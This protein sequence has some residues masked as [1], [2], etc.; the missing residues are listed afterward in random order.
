MSKRKGMDKAD[1]ERSGEGIS[2][3]AVAAGLTARVFAA[4]WIA[5][6]QTNVQNALNAADR[7]LTAP[8]HA[9]GDHSDSGS[10]HDELPEF[11]RPSAPSTPA[12]ATVPAGFMRV[13]HLPGREEVTLWGVKTI[14]SDALSRAAKVDGWLRD[15][16]G[17]VSPFRWTGVTFGEKMGDLVGNLRKRAGKWLQRGRFPLVIPVA[18]LHRPMSL[19]AADTDFVQEVQRYLSEDQEVN[20]W[21]NTVK[22]SVRHNL[23]I[24]GESTTMVRSYR[25]EPP[26]GL[27]LWDLE[28]WRMNDMPFQKPKHKEE[29]REALGALKRVFDAYVLVKSMPRAPEDSMEAVLADTLDVALLDRSIESIPVLLTAVP[30]ATDGEQYPFASGPC[31]NTQSA[32]VAVLKSGLAA[33]QR[34][35]EINEN[36]KKLDSPMATAAQRF[37][38]IANHALRSQGL[39]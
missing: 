27:L 26:I 39:S 34:V 8:M 23:Q 4:M 32:A 33:A 11:E 13:G 31:T 20:D 21:Y 22:E 36:E 29:R 2:G 14:K 7:A 3:V 38:G 5:N 28:D 15:P 6:T 1:V 37:I 18:M 12:T 10:D 25:Q 30:F 19:D 24:N 35:Y 9:R 16:G 17:H